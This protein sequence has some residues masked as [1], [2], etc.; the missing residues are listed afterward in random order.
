VSSTRL[1]G[2]AA[3]RATCRDACTVCG[4]RSANYGRGALNELG[5]GHICD[6][7]PEV[8]GWARSGV[9]LSMSLVHFVL[10]TKS[11]ES[12]LDLVSSK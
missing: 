4:G 9:V 3:V 2:G 12:F 1:D 8:N 5:R 7:R 6:A 10:F 11:S